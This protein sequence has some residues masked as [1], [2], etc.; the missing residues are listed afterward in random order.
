MPNE[1]THSPYPI[2]AVNGQCDPSGKSLPRE[3]GSPV[4]SAAA[5]HS[6]SPV[7]QTPPEQRSDEAGGSPLDSVEWKCPACEGADLRECVRGI[8]WG[9][10]GDG[11]EGWCNTAAKP[12]V[13]VEYSD[14][15]GRSTW[16]F[17]G[18]D[19]WDDEAVDV[20][21]I[22]DPLTDE[23]ARESDQRAWERAVWVEARSLARDRTNAL[24]VAAL[25]ASPLEVARSL[26]WIVSHAAVRMFD[27]GDSSIV[28]RTEAWDAAADWIM[29]RR[30]DA[31]RL[32]RDLNRKRV[33][34][35]S[36]SLLWSDELAALRRAG[37]TDADRQARIERKAKGARL[38]ALR[39]IHRDAR[40]WLAHFD[41]AAARSI[42]AGVSAP[43]LPDEMR[44]AYRFSAAVQALA[45]AGGAS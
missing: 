43:I 2:H 37:C 26:A 1:P 5:S 28:E 16:A 15:A 35:F 13:C 36:S 44:A 42:A 30:H 21:V 40:A 45:E 23:A 27:A 32:A 12:V 31:L 7:G 4:S 11:D 25:L 22:P 24:R 19:A 38:R 18:H 3:S 10:F 9:E 39:S 33:E 8:D 41:R 14:T 34:L 29:G 6:Y 20:E 17:R